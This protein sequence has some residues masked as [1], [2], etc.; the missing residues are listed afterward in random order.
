MLIC[1]SCE[2][3]TK[4]Y[5]IGMCS[6]CYRKLRKQEDPNFFKTIPRTKENREWR[7]KN[8]DKVK[9]AKL[10]FRSKP[11]YI[12]KERNYRL[13][14]T[15][16][17]SLSQYNEM[18]ISQGGVCTICLKPETRVASN[19][20]VNNMTVDHDHTC[21][22]GPFSCG[23][24][25]R[26]LLCHACNVSVGLLNENPD[27]MRRMAEYIESYKRAVGAPGSEDQ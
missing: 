15:Y 6:S 10:T 26:K 13:T 21:C 23:K 18:L 14:K 1:P 7:R 19:G 8:P 5:W 4:R 22:N 16:N 12:D 3:E 11:D 27:R 9:A 20:K 25:I 2:K 24:C 17:L